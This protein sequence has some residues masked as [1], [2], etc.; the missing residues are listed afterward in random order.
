MSQPCSVCGYVCSD[1]DTFCPACG[2]QLQTITQPQPTTQ[3]VPP[4]PVIQPQPTAQPVQP[5]QSYSTEPPKKKS[6]KGLWIGLGI[7]GG[8]LLLL[9]IVAVILIVIL[10]PMILATINHNPSLPN[11][12][13]ISSNADFQEYYYP[14]YDNISFNSEAFVEATTEEP[15]TE[16]STEAPADPAISGS[17]ASAFRAEDLTILSVEGDSSISPAILNL[18]E[19]WGYFISSSGELLQAGNMTYETPAGFEGKQCQTG[20]NLQIGNSIDSFVTAYGID[21]TNAIWQVYKTD[22]YEYYYY[23]TTT[24]PELSESTNLIFAWYKTGDTWNRILPEQIFDY[25]QKGTIPECDYLLMYQISAN[26]D[27]NADLIQIT[28][29]T[30]DYF[31]KFYSSWSTLD[32]L[33]NNSDTESETE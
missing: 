30:S 17:E 27:Y 33:L 25:W 6:H 26:S 3:P 18:S 21:S 28:Y 15:A 8:V 16:A 32:A 1:S 29:G 4:Q 11:S 19:N 9:I 12:T 2:T 13:G 20:R 23:S 24:K 7:G 22:S 31:N 10:A 5:Q 14:D